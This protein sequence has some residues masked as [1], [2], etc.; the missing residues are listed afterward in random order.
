M[1]DALMATECQYIEAAGDVVGATEN[2][3]GSGF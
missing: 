3:T 2:D 1:I